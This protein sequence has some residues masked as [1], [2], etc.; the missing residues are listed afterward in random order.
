MWTQHSV[1]WR[2]WP[3][4]PPPPR[5]AHQICETERIIRACNA[6]GTLNLPLRERGP[7]FAAAHVR[8]MYRTACNRMR[9]NQHARRAEAYRKLTAACRLLSDGP[10]QLRVRAQLVADGEHRPVTRAIRCTVNARAIEEYIRAAGPEADE[11]P[12]HSDGSLEA[13]M[14]RPDGSS[15]AGW[16]FG[17]KVMRLTVT[18][19]WAGSSSGTATRD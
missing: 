2:A 1:R 5:R 19:A 18:M 12:R 11:V 14:A 8:R 15:C 9:G 13:A 6:F 10:R 3:P 4:L 16:H 7:A 17:C